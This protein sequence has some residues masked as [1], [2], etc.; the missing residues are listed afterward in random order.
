M[1]QLQLGAAEAFDILIRLSQNTG[2]KLIFLADHIVETGDLAWTTSHRQAGA[3]G[4]ADDLGTAQG[5]EVPEDRC[6]G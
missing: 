1:A 5:S 3:D 4:G 2:V 6:P